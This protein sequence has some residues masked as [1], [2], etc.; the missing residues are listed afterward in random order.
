MTGLFDFQNASD[1]GD[2]LVGGGVGRLVN[3]DDAG[4]DVVLDGSLQGRAAVWDGGEM[5]RSHIELIPALQEK[6][7]IGR[8]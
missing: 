2:D 8:V 5:G 6:G 4:A 1:P 3:V 7:P